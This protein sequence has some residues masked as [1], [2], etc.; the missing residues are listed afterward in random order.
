MSITLYKNDLPDDLIFTDSVAIDS[1][2]MGLNQNRDRLCLIQLS[3]GD[4]TAHLVQ[5]EK[6]CYDAPNLKKLLTDDTI[7]KIFHFARFDLAVIKKFLGVT[8]SPVFC[9]KVASR[10][11]RTYTD[12]H[13]LKAVCK[14]IMGIDLSKQQQSSD[15]GADELTQDQMKYAASD[16]LYL[17]EIKH[18][19]EL[20]LERENRTTLAHECFEFLPSRAELDLLGWSDVDIFSHDTKHAR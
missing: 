9:T 1:E 12:K 8:C 10:L 3:A 20:M 11:C 19:L 6:G 7:T 13:S 17:H 18:K 5:F 15:W 14:E 4:N 16:V 2:T